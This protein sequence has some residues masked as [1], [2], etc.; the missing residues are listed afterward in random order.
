[1]LTFLRG[2]FVSA[3]RTF[4]ESRK[5]LFWEKIPGLNNAT[6]SRV[7]MFLIFFVFDYTIPG[8]SFKCKLR[9][10]WAEFLSSRVPD[11]HY[12]KKTAGET[13]PDLPDHSFI[14]TPEQIRSFI[15]ICFI[16]YFRWKP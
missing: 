2:I 7:K 9:R 14:Y 6:K 13:G 3:S 15:L 11:Q 10:L 4:P 5:E 1:M 12:S 8:M 16:A